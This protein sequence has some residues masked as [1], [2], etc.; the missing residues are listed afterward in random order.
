M[1]ASWFFVGLQLKVHYS[2]LT[3]I[4]KDRRDSMDC[5]SEMLAIWLQS[6]EA[7]AAE[8]VYALKSAYMSVLANKIAVKYGEK[9]CMCVCMHGV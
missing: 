4:R 3:V 7:S 8:L 2:K 6:G 9:V 5:L 1:A